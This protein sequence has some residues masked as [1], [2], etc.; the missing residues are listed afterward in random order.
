M[1]VEQFVE[2]SQTS[3]IS[4]AMVK[5]QLNATREGEGVFGPQ[6]Q[7]ITQHVKGVGAET[8]Q[9]PCV[10]QDSSEFLHSSD[11]PDSTLVSLKL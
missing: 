8:Q 9:F 7:M 10:A 1:R 5:H 3:L 6:S 2:H 11:P 4:I